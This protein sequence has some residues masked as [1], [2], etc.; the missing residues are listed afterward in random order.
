MLETRNFAPSKECAQFIR[1]SYVSEA[2]L[3]DDFVLEDSILGETGFVRI[4]LDGDWEVETEPGNWHG[5]GK[6]A[7]F[8]SN[9]R[10]Q[11]VRLRGSIRFAS[12]SVR[13]SAWRNIFKERAHVYADK[14][15][16]LQQDW[17]AD[18]TALLEQVQEAKGDAD[19]AA[20][21]ERAIMFRDARIGRKRIDHAIARLEQLARTNSTMKMDDVAHELGMS[22]R[23][24]ERRCLDT[25][26]ISPKLVF[27]RSRF[28]DMVE[29]MRGMGKPGEELLARLRY[30]DESH[31][32]R[33]FR[34][35]VGTTPGRFGKAV[36][37][38]F[39]ASL[40]LRTQGKAIA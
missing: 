1:R 17:G 9:S 38:L 27:Q 6:I 30:F 10:A 24:M 5:A 22:V 16:P 23:Q 11:R 21:M 12:F 32:N 18:A 2:R 34:R 39:D 40:Q 31:L 15:V 20:A 33:E 28:L 29:T 37:P 13:P 19:I 35:F 36:T 25:F 4:L 14:V 8:G 3:A 26:G 7:L